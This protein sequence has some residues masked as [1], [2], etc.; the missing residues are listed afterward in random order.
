MKRIP[1]I[2]TLFLTTLLLFL[3]SSSCKDKNKK[4]YCE[5]NPSECPDIK[6][7]KDYFCFKIG[8]WWVYEEETTLERDSVYVTEYSN[9]QSNYYFDVRMLSSNTGYY[10]H[11][12]SE[13]AWGASNCNESGPINNKC[14]LIKVSK[15]KTGDYIGEGYC[16]FYKIVKD[17][18]IA[19]Y[20]PNFENN[21]VIA[22]DIFSTYTIGGLNFNK[23]IKIHE[24]N[25]FIEGKQPTN[26]FYSQGIGLIRKELID[27]NQ[28]WN[29]VSYHIEP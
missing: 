8:T 14:A 9:N 25:N 3:T 29:L 12:W 10:Y 11:F 15:Y 5:E 21:R 4:T 13:Y 28:V 27:S 22:E 24:L 6:E 18:K 26:H 1:H 7:V 17:S 16:F 19:N 20:N 2:T 23:T